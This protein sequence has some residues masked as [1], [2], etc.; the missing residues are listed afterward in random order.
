MPDL[1]KHS[2]S[3]T[4]TQNVRGRKKSLNVIYFVDSNRTKS[5]KLSLRKA[6]WLSCFLGA[7]ITMAFAN[8]AWLI[9]EINAGIRKDNK[10]SKLMSTIFNYQ[11]K[12]DQIYERTYPK[13]IQEQNNSQYVAMETPQPLEKNKKELE[14]VK[15]SPSEQQSSPAPNLAKKSIE[16]KIAQKSDKKDKTNQRTIKINP[17]TKEESP[18]S[19][20]QASTQIG[21]KGLTLS[22]AIKNRI[23]PDKAIGRLWGVATYKLSDGSEQLITSP[24]N[25][26]HKNGGIPEGIEKAPS[27]K[28]RHYKA[29]LLFFKK[30]KSKGSFTKIDVFCVARKTTHH[31]KTVLVGKKPKDIAKNILKK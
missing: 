30:P 17:K 15:K 8:T 25:I 6:F 29:K 21:T 14:E 10:I 24:P 5:F 26:I 27:F 31:L 13:E 20:E 18:I 22:F 19:I 4:T 9:H 1:T 11:T 2:Q 3:S 7:I 28:I 12:Y 23:G 16:A